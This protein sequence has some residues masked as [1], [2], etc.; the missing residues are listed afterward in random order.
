[1]QQWCNIG[2]H[3]GIYQVVSITP[4]RREL[5]L[6]NCCLLT[7]TYCAPAMNFVEHPGWQTN[8]TCCKRLYLEHVNIHAFRSKRKHINDNPHCH[9]KFSGMEMT[10]DSSPSWNPPGTFLEAP[11]TI[12]TM[13]FSLCWWNIYLKCLLFDMCLESSWFQLCCFYNL[14]IDSIQSVKCYSGGRKIHFFPSISEI[15]SHQCY[16]CVQYTK[17]Y[18]RA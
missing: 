13:M 9:S 3:H 11:P 10:Q 6:V 8:V 5:I 4:R 12:F 14:N 18:F 15:L 2:K 16:Y 7:H 17:R 1:M